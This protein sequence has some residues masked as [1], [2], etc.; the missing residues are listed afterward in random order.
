MTIFFLSVLVI[1]LYFGHRLQCEESLYAILTATCSSSARFR[2][3]RDSM[4]SRFPVNTLSVIVKNKV[5]SFSAGNRIDIVKNEFRL[6]KDLKIMTKSYKEKFE[7]KCDR[8][9][10][11]LNAFRV[12]SNHDDSSWN[13]ERTRHAWMTAKRE[14]EPIGNSEVKNRACVAPSL[15]S[16][17]HL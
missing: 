14:M 4:S 1:H 6:V 12:A 3:S 13:N 16:S 17:G 10:F 9:T 8:F 7:F 11:L 15:F 5:N 2:N